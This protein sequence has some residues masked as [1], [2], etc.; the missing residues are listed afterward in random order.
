MYEFF[1]EIAYTLANLMMSRSETLDLLM[2]Y[3]NM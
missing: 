3:D 2:D 1:P